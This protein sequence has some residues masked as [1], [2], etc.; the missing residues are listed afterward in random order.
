M[1]EDLNLSNRPD[2]EVRIIEQRIQSINDQINK[3]VRQKEKLKADLQEKSKYTMKEEQ[4]DKS[5]VD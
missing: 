2:R 4:G 5:N 3:L 1:N